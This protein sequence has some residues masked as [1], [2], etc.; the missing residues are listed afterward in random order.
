[1]PSQHITRKTFTRSNHFPEPGSEGERSSF[2]E[3]QQAM[4]TQY[5]KIFPDK[6]AERTVV[7]IPSL[8]LDIEI[9]SKV[10]GAVHYEERLLC[11][12]MLLRMTVSSI[13]PFLKGAAWDAISLAAFRLSL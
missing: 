12:L 11:L 2:N 1:M 7:I 10:K 4:K 8:T 5:D 6:L 9:L 3:I 13:I